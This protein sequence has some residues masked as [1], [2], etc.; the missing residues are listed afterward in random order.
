MSAHTTFPADNWLKEILNECRKSIQELEIGETE[1]W[2]KLIS[3]KTDR[4]FVWIKVGIA[5]ISLYLPL[6]LESDAELLDAKTSGSW[7]KF[8]SRYRIDTPTKIPKAIE[9]I[10][11]AYTHDRYL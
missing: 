10:T 11:K 7:R 5:V 9:L 6:P 2:T 1:I 8:E 4:V 3:P